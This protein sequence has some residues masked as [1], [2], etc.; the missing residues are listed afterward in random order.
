MHPKSSSVQ[1]EVAG[2]IQKRTVRKRSLVQPIY[3]PMNIELCQVTKTITMKTLPP[4]LPPTPACNHFTGIGLLALRANLTPDERLGALAA[5]KKR[6]PALPIPPNTPVT[7]IVTR[8]IPPSSVRINSLAKPIPRRIR[9]TWEMHEDVLSSGQKRNFQLLLQPEAF[10]TVA[11]A[12]YLIREHRAYQEYL[13]MKE[14]QEKRR[15][16][17]SQKRE[18]KRVTGMILD[19]LIE[20]IYLIESISQRVED[21]LQKEYRNFGLTVITNDSLRWDLTYSIAKDLIGFF[22]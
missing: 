18:T 1:N 4:R 15:V 19:D 13:A 20:E 14:A 7:T 6:P 22:T 3:E 21:K 8:N 5:P 10:T 2:G 12:E 9:Q 16:R 17:L 11:Q